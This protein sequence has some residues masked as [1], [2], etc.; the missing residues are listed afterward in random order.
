MYLCV[1]HVGVEP[2]DG[3]ERHF[4]VCVTSQTM[5]AELIGDQSRRVVTEQ[6]NR[7]LLSN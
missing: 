7:E 2:V 6:S 3:C 4:N 1:C 5:F